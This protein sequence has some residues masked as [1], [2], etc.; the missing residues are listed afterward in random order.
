MSAACGSAL[1]SPMVVLEIGHDGS[2]QLSGCRDLTPGV[3]GLLVAEQAA[4][5]CTLNP[6]TT[7]DRI[8]VERSRS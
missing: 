7:A 2:V 3:I 4:R 5:Y 8:A 1:T 6:A